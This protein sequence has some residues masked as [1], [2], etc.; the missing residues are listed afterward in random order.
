MQNAK[1]FTIVE[2]KNIVLSTMFGY[3]RFR[4]IEKKD[5]RRSPHHSCLIQPGDI[6]MYCDLKVIFWWK[7]MEKDI[8]KFV[9]NYLICKQVKA[10]YQ[11]SSGLL[12]PLDI[13]KYK[14]EHITMNFVVDFLKSMSNHEA[15]WVIIDRLTKLAHFLPVQI[16]VSMDQFAQLYANKMVRLHGVQ[17][18]SYHI[19]T[20]GLHRTFRSLVHYDEVGEQKILGPKSWNK[21]F[22]LSNRFK[23]SMKTA[24]DRKI[25]QIE[26]EKN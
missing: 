15:I 5:P 3:A 20:Q 25:M 7:N 17:F 12:T 19:K 16:T 21:Q 11:R 14:W 4:R 26:G 1:G 8:A 22:R 18:Q 13:L 23:T 24:Q 9:E 6:K 2:D 10:E